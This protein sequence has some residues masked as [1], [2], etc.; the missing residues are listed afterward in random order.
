[1]AG[2]SG[3]GSP[4]L[5]VPFLW[6]QE[7][8]C[9]GE[10]SAAGRPRSQRPHVHIL[11]RQEVRDQ[12]SEMRDKVKTQR[13]AWYIKE[14][15]KVTADGQKRKAEAEG[16]VGGKEVSRPQRGTTTTGMRSALGGRATPGVGVGG[17]WLCYKAVV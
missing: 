15:I 16:K 5:K 9:W 7:P 3:Q 12:G 2:A 8:G 13:E 1:M 17:P 10:V 6:A 4:G 11:E 14:N